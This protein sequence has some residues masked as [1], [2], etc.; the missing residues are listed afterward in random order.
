[1]GL[2]VIALVLSAIL[3]WH[4]LKGGSMFGCDGASLCE[5]VLSSR[6]SVIAGRVPVSGLAM[7]VY[8]AM[9]IACLHIGPAMEGSLRRLAWAVLLILAGAIVGMAIW[10]TVVQ[11]WMIG[12]FCP[13]CMTEHIT[14]LLMSAIIIWRAFL[15]SDRPWYA[16]GFVANGL[17]LAGIVAISQAIFIPQNVYREGKSKNNLP[18]IAYHDVPIIGSPDAP[19]VVKLLFDYE[20]PHCQ[21]IHSMLDD[22]VSRYGDKLAFALCPTP[23]NTECN[24]YVHHQADA[25]KNSCE[26]TKIGLAVWVARREAF[27]VF[28]KWMFSFES[29]DKWHARS[30]QAAR[31]KAVE[32]VGQAAFGA[33][34]ASPW[35]A[36]YMETCVQIYGQTLQNGRGGVP[37]LILGSH[38]VIPGS[39]DAGDLIKILQNSLAVPKP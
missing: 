9:L 2:N 11:K 25:F 5:Q 8:L 29:G 19:Y 34:Q 31:A 37:K 7:G 26:L 14:G 27:P 32:L 21:K 10:F 6:W 15:K 23:L 33:A 30:P 22:A 13:Y 18:V 39:G 3:S 16:M 35:I 17:L 12:A 38:W 1:M 36:R 24:P 4:Y 28:D 20:C